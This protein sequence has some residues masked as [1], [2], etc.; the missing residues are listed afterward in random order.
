[1]WGSPPFQRFSESFG[2]GG[3]S[4][5]G[6]HF[7]PTFHGPELCPTVSS[8]CKGGWGSGVPVYVREEPQALS[9]LYPPYSRGGKWG[10]VN[11]SGLFGMNQWQSQDWNSGLVTPS[12][13]F[14]VVSQAL[15]RST[16]GLKVSEGQSITTRKNFLL[17]I[18]CQS[19]VH[20]SEDTPKENL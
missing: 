11:R 1:M 15:W 12:S 4:H 14:P 18:Q 9:L 8:R 6:F 20:L 13:L 2:K 10:F 16:I 5:V 7:M 3:R 17:S 19:L